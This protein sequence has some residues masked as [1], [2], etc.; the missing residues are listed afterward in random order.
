VHWGQSQSDANGQGVPQNDVEAYKW[1]SLAA[2]Q[3]ASDAV[4][5]RDIFRGR[6]TPVQI[7]EGQKL[8]AAWKP[9]PVVSR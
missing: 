2:A 6:M 1:F 5:N 9:K 3:G 4:K 8:L 7:A